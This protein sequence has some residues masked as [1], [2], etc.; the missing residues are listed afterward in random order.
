[1]VS[2]L[3]RPWPEFNRPFPLGIN[4]MNGLSDV[5]NSIPFGAFHSCHG[6]SRI[7]LFMISVALT[8]SST[9]LFRSAVGQS[10]IVANC[11]SRS[12]TI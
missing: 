4:E 8:R 12:L 11:F 6:F 10:I 1:M 5:T 3:P 2:V 7:T 9:K